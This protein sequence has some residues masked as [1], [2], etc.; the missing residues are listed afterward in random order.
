MYPPLIV[1][2]PLAFS[3]PNGGDVLELSVS[4]PDS[5]VGLSSR[6]LP[7]TDFLHSSL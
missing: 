7:S 5:R 4:H 6:P 3:D 1:L 2:Q